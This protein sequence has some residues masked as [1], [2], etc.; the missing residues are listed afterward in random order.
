MA[1]VINVFRESI[2]DVSLWVT[3]LD[4]HCDSR[5]DKARDKKLKTTEL[6]MNWTE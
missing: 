2:S 3:P 5:T 6:W 1:D 4:I